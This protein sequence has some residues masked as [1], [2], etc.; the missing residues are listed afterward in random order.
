M[1]CGEHQLAGMVNVVN[2]RCEVQ[3]CTK[4]PSVN[5]PGVRPASRCGE[6]KLPGMT[7]KFRT[8]AATDCSDEIKEKILEKTMLPQKRGEVMKL[9]RLQLIGYE[10]K[11]MAVM[12]NDQPAALC[13][14]RDSCGRYPMQSQV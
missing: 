6:H 4:R 13:L 2:K 5:Y 11:Q 9:Q 3:G 1:Y 12:L 8:M 10:G 14:S 7:G